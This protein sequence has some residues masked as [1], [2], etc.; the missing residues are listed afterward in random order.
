[1]PNEKQTFITSEPSKLE[2]E[3]QRLSGEPNLFVLFIF[4]FKP[5]NPFYPAPLG[6]K[7]R[8]EERKN[9]FFSKDKKNKTS[10][11]AM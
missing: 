8:N 11:D 2:E 3:S 4:S 1:M 7:P 6:A 10:D 5:S 9:A